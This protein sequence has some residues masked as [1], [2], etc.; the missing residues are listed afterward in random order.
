M[1]KE[2]AY[3]QMSYLGY[4]GPT[5]LKSIPWWIGDKYLFH[6]LNKADRNSHKLACLEKGYMTL[7][8]PTDC[9]KPTRLGNERF[10]FG[11]LNNARKLTKE[12]ISLWS[13]ILK[14]CADSDLLLKSISFKHEKEARE[15]IK[16][17]KNY[18]IDD[19]R[20]VL[21]PFQDRFE[22]HL[23]AYNHIDVALDPIPYG[24]ATTTAEALWMG[25]PVICVE[26]SSMASNLA[27]S[28]I[29]SANCAELIT[30]NEKAYLNL[31]KSLYEKGP[32]EHQKG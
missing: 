19:S 15:I 14:E 3:I 24:G 2:P 4:P 17:F 26:G 31:A 8:C 27:A 32:R 28:V 29:A 23:E 9:P 20:L 13:E 7:P 11:S 12:T 30:K 5:F 22:D 10:K 6:G 1:P 21:L 16:R 25:V 18:G